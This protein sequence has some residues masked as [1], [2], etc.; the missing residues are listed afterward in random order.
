MEGPLY[1]NNG[2]EIIWDKV[3]GLK[4]YRK[5]KEIE[6]Y[7]KKMIER[8]PFKQNVKEVAFEKLLKYMEVFNENNKYL[9]CILI[10]ARKR[11]YLSQVFL[12][13]R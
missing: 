6:D 10:V 13:Y 2:F 11:T 12:F 1:E 8:V 4:M 3:L 7:C 9:D 5:R